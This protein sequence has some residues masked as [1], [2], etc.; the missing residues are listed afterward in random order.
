MSS[1]SVSSDG[2]QRNPGCQVS[3]SRELPAGLLAEARTKPGGWVYEIVGDFGPDDAV[4]ATAVKGA[5]KVNDHGE[6]VGD[7]LPNPVFEPPEAAS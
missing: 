6:I 4:P 7:F 1:G 3:S 2:C 5:W